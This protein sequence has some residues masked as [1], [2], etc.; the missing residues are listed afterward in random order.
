MRKKV[1][2]SLL[3]SK[4]QQQEIITEIHFKLSEHELP[5]P[6][7]DVR[8]EELSKLGKTDVKVSSGRLIITIDIPRLDKSGY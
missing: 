6:T 2:F 8:A 5:I 1:V 4:D 3:L 7:S